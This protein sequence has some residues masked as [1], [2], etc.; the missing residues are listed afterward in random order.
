MITRI[1]SAIAE[2][3]RNFACTLPLRGSQDRH[4][5]GWAV[6]LAGVAMML[7]GGVAGLLSSL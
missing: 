5:L 6:T 3:P 4:R 1:R 7:A 2:R